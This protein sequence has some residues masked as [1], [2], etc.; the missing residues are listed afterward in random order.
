MSGF[1]VTSSELR[2]K[3]EEL[4]TI[5]GQFKN[6]VT[7]LVN[8]EESLNSMWDGPANEM[9]H[10]AFMSDKGQMDEFASMIE[11]YCAALERIAAKYEEKERINIELAK[12]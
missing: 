3:A 10:N 6:S 2:R 1:L 11:K 9:F 5:N 12:N 4:R 7:K 8:T